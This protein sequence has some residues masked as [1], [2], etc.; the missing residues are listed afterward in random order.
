MD[1]QILIHGFNITDG[2]SNTI[3]RL[4]P[5]LTK[6]IDLDYGWF[7]LLQVRFR[8]KSVAKKLLSICKSEDTIYAHSNGCAIVAR[9]LKIG[10][11][12]K[13]IVFIHPA[14]DV[15]DERLLT[16][17]YKKLVVFYSHKDTA[18]WLAKWLPFHNWGAMGTYGCKLDNKRIV[19]VNDDMKHSEGFMKNP[20]MYILNKE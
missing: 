2:G 7:G 13:N 1:K 8:N 12:V 9:A 11:K 16:K 14:L 20:K 3:D 17:N 10:L 4:K 19:N 6:P 15:D 5:F 18:T